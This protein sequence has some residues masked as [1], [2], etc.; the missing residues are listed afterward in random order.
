MYTYTPRYIGYIRRPGPKSVLM[1]IHRGPPPAI[2]VGHG[3]RVARARAAYSY[4]IYISTLKVVLTWGF[5]GCRWGA[6]SADGF[7]EGLESG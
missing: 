2:K 1:Q 5:A 3:Y 7:F 4:I 6:D